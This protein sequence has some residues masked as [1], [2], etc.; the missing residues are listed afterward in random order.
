MPRLAPPSS[1]PAREITVSAAFATQSPDGEIIT[2]FFEYSNCSQVHINSRRYFRSLFVRDPRSPDFSTYM[3]LNTNNRSRR[4]P[5]SPKRQERGS[6]RCRKNNSSSPKNGGIAMTPQMGETGVVDQKENRRPDLPMAGAGLL[7]IYTS[8]IC[9]PWHI[10]HMVLVSV[11]N[12]K[13]VGIAGRA[14]VG[15]RALVITKIRF[16]RL[17]IVMTR[18]YIPHATTSS[19]ER[20]RRCK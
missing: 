9:Q 16:G 1:V 12:T 8:C 4:T 17:F 6:P 14:Q 20:W 13:S 3:S 2:T 19:A 15:V 7:F 10:K 5:S 18:R 11:R